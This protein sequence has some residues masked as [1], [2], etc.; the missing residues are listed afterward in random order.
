MT[1]GQT[2]STRSSWGLLV[3]MGVVA[4]AAVAATAVVAVDSA[5]AVRAFSMTKM[6]IADRSAVRRIPMASPRSMLP[7]GSEARCSAYLE[8][9]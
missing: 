5:A 2:L 7:R 8:F 4:V 1:S 9:G 6:A 3:G